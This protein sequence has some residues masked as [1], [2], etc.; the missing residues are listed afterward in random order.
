MKLPTD[1][2]SVDRLSRRA[3]L[4]HPGPLPLGEG[5]SSAVTG[6]NLSR[7]SLRRTGR[8]VMANCTFPLPAGE[9]LRVRESRSTSW[10]FGIRLLLSVA[11]VTFAGDLTPAQTE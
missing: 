5:E 1:N 8:H 7:K 2:A 11:T 10:R 6:E 3:A 4:P 9:G